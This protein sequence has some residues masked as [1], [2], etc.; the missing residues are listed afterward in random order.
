MQR[1]TSDQIEEIVTHLDLEQ[2]R[3]F[4]LFAHKGSFNGVG[5][6]VHRS[7]NTVRDRMLHASKLF[8]SVFGHALLKVERGHYGLTTHGQYVAA[9]YSELTEFLVRVIDGYRSSTYIYEVPC[10]KTTLP[11]FYE[12]VRALPE[13][14]EFELRP[15][16]KRTA[17]L[18]VHPKEP[19]PSRIAFGSI[20]ASVGEPS[21]WGVPTP[22]MPSIKMLIFE[23][24][25]LYLLGKRSLGLGGTP[26]IDTV[27]SKGITLLMPTDGVAWKFAQ[28]NSP[29]WNVRHPQQHT[30][31]PYK[32][33]GLEMLRHEDRAAMVLHGPINEYLLEN[34]EMRTWPLRQ[35]NGMEHQA[36][37]GLIID[38][39]PKMDDSHLNQIIETAIELFR[40]STDQE[41]D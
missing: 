28:E 40:P 22:I 39:R 16:P 23:R 15:D 7:S 27:I 41:G 20:L 25:Q 6:V 13:W 14:A 3:L 24:E 26:D 19:G 35:R 36:L 33:F 8:E 11:R 29:E 21:E 5:L 1:T 9:S 12:L 38:E 34:P 10:T 18:Q 31:I 37:T 30:P 32:D 17:D 2:V 4:S